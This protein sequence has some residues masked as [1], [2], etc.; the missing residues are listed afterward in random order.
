MN[1]KDI[2]AVKALLSTP[3]KIVIIPH[4]NPDGDAIGSTL[5]LCHYLNNNG[6][7]ANIV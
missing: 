5:A 7:S 6:H 3:R 4:K 1:L 2:K